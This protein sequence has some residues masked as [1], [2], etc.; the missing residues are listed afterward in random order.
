MATIPPTSVTLLKDISD[1]TASARWTDF[2][3]RYSPAML[4]FLRERYPSVEAEDVIQETL[5]ALTK[6][7]PDYH[8][9]PDGNGH[10]RNWLMGIVKHKADTLSSSGMKTM[11][12][13]FRVFCDEK[14]YPIYFHCIGGADRTGSL[15]Y[16][17]NGILG[18]DRHDLETDWESTFYPT[19][20]EMRK[21]YTGP[22]YWC[23][24]NHF[25]DGF[26][27]YGDASTSWNDRIELYLLDCGVTKEE[28][29][30]FRSIM[31]E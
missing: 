13:N 25:N 5:L 22:S 6:A 3:N 29:A 23:G 8:Y 4:G 17:L 28:I 19:L 10:F 16:V 15:A 14:N 11:A 21:D 26:A 1:G 31:L 18:V 9:T 30:K 2:Y 20:P 12:E 24:E 7:M 27:K